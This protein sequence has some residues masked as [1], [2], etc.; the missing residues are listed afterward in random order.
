[1]SRETK[2]ERE[3]RENE[4][5]LIEEYQEKHENRDRKVPKK[6]ITRNGRAPVVDDQVIEDCYHLA[7]HGLIKTSIV[8]AL[9]ISMGTFYKARRLYNEYDERPL[10]DREKLPLY[11]Q[12]QISLIQAFHDGQREFIADNLVFFS[13][14]GDI[15]VRW[16]F[17]E[18]IAKDYRLKKEVD[19]EELDVL[20]TRAYGARKAEAVIAI[21]LD[22]EFDDAE[23]NELGEPQ[24]QPADDV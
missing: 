21:L 17:F 12:K 20:L 19:L 11:Q 24:E 14:T 5:R 3:K 18:R 2:Q 6:M 13:K 23:N 7:K 15:R 16:K 1:M 9:P 10:E 4:E 22:E 8:Q